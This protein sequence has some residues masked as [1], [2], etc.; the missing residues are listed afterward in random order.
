MSTLTVFSLLACLG[1][2]ILSG[3]VLGKDPS[4]R[5]YQVV[6]LFGIASAVWSLGFAVLYSLKEAESA[7][8]WIRFY[9]MGL[10]FIPATFYHFVVTYIPQKRISWQ[11]IVVRVGYFLSFI[12]LLLIW[13]PFFASGVSQ[14]SW[15]FYPTVGVAS[16]AFNIMFATYIGLGFIELVRYFKVTSGRKR[17][18]VKYLLASTII[19]FGLGITNFLPLY[20][21]KNVY[22]LGHFGAPIAI[23]ILAYAIVR[24]RL[25]DIDFVIRRSVIYSVLTA[26][27]ATAYVSIVFSL[28]ANSI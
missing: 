19:G 18:Q 20:G 1:V 27:L 22:P 4:K 2:L 11:R 15:G 7:L 3:L 12:F 16:R 8:F 21:F 5:L 26:I 13:T 23:V 14:Y 17:N 10:V 25:L 9:E 6:G 24:H 28:G